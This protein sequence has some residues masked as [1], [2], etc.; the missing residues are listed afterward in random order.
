MASRY[1]A[2]DAAGRRCRDPALAESVALPYVTDVTRASDKLGFSGIGSS[3]A[4]INGAA[5]RGGATDGAPWPARTLDWRFPDS[6]AMSRSRRMQGPGGPFDTTSPAGFWDADA[7]APG[8]FAAAINPIPMWRRHA[9]S[10]LLPMTCRTRSPLGSIRFIPPDILAGVFRDRATT[11]GAARA[12]LE[13]DAGGGAPVISP[14]VGCKRAALRHRA[15]RGRLR[16]PRRRH[17]QQPTTAALPE[18]VGSAHAE[19][20]S[21]H[22]QL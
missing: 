19:R 21:S 4:P 6:G 2:H 14:L 9:P 13:T 10:W 5:P 3:T 8:R 1:R 17:P 16:E 18:A 12:T 20:R 7:C 11:F 15:N 22:P